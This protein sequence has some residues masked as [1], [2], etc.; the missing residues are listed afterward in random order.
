MKKIKFILF[1]A[2]AIV[3]QSCAKIY[4]T[5]DCFSLANSHKTIAI[6]PSK[7]SLKASKKVDA[8]SMKEQQK[9]EALSFQKEIYSWMLKR[10]MQG[11]I[12]VE[13]LDVET[14]NAKLSK[15]GY[16]N[17][18]ILSPKDICTLLKVDGI[19]TSSFSLSKPMSEGAAVAVG[20]LVGAWGSTNEVGCDLEIHDASQ[21]KMIWS[22]NH[23][24]NGG[25]FSTASRVVDA[26]MR[27]ATK[28]LPYYKN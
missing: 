20:L 18:S 9:T 27:K 23:K 6:I 2:I 24:L 25:T 28:K 19:L 15:A 13:I 5:P 16:F 26:L 22:Y 8:E 1:I 11:R 7:I 10:K 14:V 3:I 12:K 17:D 4:Y 21:S